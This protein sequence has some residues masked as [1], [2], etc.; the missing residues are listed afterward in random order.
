MSDCV[1]DTE[2][3]RSSQQSTTRKRTYNEEI[4]FI[5]GI[6]TDWLDYNIPTVTLLQARMEEGEWNCPK[7]ITIKLL[8]ELEE[9]LIDIFSIGR[10]KS[11]DSR[12]Q[13]L[14]KL[15]AEREK[16]LACLRGRDIDMDSV[17]K[18]RALFESESRPRPEDV[19]ATTSVLSSL[20]SPSEIAHSEIPSSRAITSMAMVIS[21]QANENECLQKKVRELQT[22]LLR[23]K[24]EKERL[25][26]QQSSSAASSEKGSESS[27]RMSRIN[28]R[29]ITELKYHEEVAQQRGDYI[30]RLIRNKIIPTEGF[31]YSHEEDLDFIGRFFKRICH[32]RSELS[33][34]DAEDLATMRQEY[35]ARF[36]RA[37]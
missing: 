29:L 10:S 7:E 28:R 32:P 8:Q 20:C 15:I 25:I 1:T 22:A 17:R 19:S 4:K 21:Q 11:R 5:Q 3:E 24:Q 26:S 12:S 18:V 34:D 13:I 31:F 27:D 23:E 30:D 33:P 36:H 16:V 6:R 14:G 35:F 9:K 37:S 2:T